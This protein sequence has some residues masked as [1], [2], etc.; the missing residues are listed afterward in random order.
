MKLRRLIDDFRVQE[1]NSLPIGSRGIHAVYELKKSGWTTLD[2]LGHFSRTLNIPRRNMVHAGLKDR[3]AVTSQIITVRHGPRRSFVEEN[4]EL[5][6]LGQAE[7]ETGSS[8]ITGNNFEIVLRSLSDEEHRQA[9]GSILELQQGGLPNYFDDQRFG[10]WYA[11]QGFVGAAWVREDYEQALWL[12]FA[13][14]HPDDPAAE[15]KQKAILRD[16]WKDWITCKRL[17]ERSHRRSIITF[18]C[19]KPEDFKGAW[20]IVNSDLRGLYLSALQSELWNR[21]AAAWFVKVCAPEQIEWVTF[22][23]GPIE[24][25]RRLTA[26]QV[27][28]LQSIQIPLPSARLKLDNEPLAE[29]MQS[30]LH[31]TGWSFSDLK[32]K[33][34]RD[35]FFS[36]ARRP[37]LICPGDLSG[38][39]AV[40]ELDAAKTKLCLRFSLPR[41]AYAT[42]VIKRLW[43]GLDENELSASPEE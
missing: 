15:R 27:R 12:A 39:F 26:E 8:D 6:Y 23:T 11:G 3:H 10:S 4:L 19:D 5:A 2:A 42:M 36:R 22:R 20:G 29:F 33:F 25:P 40:D 18:L 9:A 32:V 34:P 17:L 37:I 1:Q 31:Q 28:S 16:H 24:S 41:G 14:H 13:E 21:L 35:R 30:V 38:E 7:R 43:S